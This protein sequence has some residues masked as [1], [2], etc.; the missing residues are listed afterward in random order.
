MALGDWDEV[1]VGKYVYWSNVQDDVPLADLGEVLSADGSNRVVRFA[2]KE[3]KDKVWMFR[4]ADIQKETF[5]HAVVDG[6]SPHSVGLV[7]ELKGGQLLVHIEG[8]GLTA[9]RTD[10]LKSQLQPGSRVRWTISSDDIPR[11]ELGEVLLDVNAYSDIK[12]KFSAGE[13]RMRYSEMVLASECGNSITV[14]QYVYWSNVQD[15]VPLGDLGEV[16]SADGSN[17]VVRFAKKEVKDKAWMFRLAE[18]QKDAFVHATTSGIPPDAVGVVKDLKDGHLLVHIEGNGL[19]EHRTNL[20]N[21]SLQP[22]LRVRWTK[23]D[24]QIPRGHVGEVLADVNA[25]SDVKV[26]FPFGEFRLRYSEMTQAPLS[27]IPEEP[28]AK[29]KR[30]FNDFRGGRLPVEDF[31]DILKRLG[32]AE[33]DG[34]DLSSQLPRGKDGTCSG[35]DFISY[36]F[37]R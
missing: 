23:S 12:V 7:R 2:K 26:K 35:K 19:T 9:N 6:V 3:V 11:G 30:I 16:L 31:V 21:S 10:L 33:T 20:L 34:L 4:L 8:N 32:F 22:G 15:G 29:L 14:G 18:I 17:R 5:V 28:L 36:L 37:P 27:A 13:F 24:E 25:Y 1:A